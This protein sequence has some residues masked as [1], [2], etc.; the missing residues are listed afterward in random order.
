MR[1]RVGVDYNEPPNKVK[2][3]LFKAA[4]SANGVL[5]HPPVKIFLVDFS[6][7][8]V[9]YEIKFYMGNHARINAVN[10]AV[11]TNVWY[12]LKRQ[13]I[14]I[15]Y[16]I[17]TLQVERRGPPPVHEQHAEAQAIL[18]QEPLFQCLTDAQIHNLVTQSRL[19]HFGAGE[20]VI[21]EGA[22]G[23]SMFVLLNGAAQVSISK[24][25]SMIQVANLSSGDCFGEMSLLTGEK[26]SATVS[27][28]GDCYVMEID[29]PV[30]S[31]VIHNAPECLEQLS[32]LLAK[33]KMETEGIIKEAATTGAQ[34]ETTEKEYRANFMRRLKTFFEL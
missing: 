1:I 5:P 26:R 16:P 11:R 9:T 12:E 27:A 19:N 7:S 22:D 4:S 13:K 10:D 28:E 17:R 20:R 6:E 18:R 24:N 8:A 30:M 31:E 15:P 23:H 3:A 34:T 21:E 33:R 32:D 2:A 25:G 14:K 29:K